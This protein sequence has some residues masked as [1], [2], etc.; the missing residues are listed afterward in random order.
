M[1]TWDLQR[2][3]LVSGSGRGIPRPRCAGDSSQATRR[4]P[5]PRLPGLARGLVH[6]GVGG[7]Q[8]GAT[9]ATGSRSPNFKSLLHPQA[10]RP[11]QIRLRSQTRVQKTVFILRLI[12]FPDDRNN[13][14]QVTL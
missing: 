9:E 10:H 1:G 5:S 13:H 3:G 14:L 7:L 6:N 12:A 2:A 8:P 11:A 4:E